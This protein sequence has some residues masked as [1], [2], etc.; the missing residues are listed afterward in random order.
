VSRTSS[1]STSS[2]QHKSFQFQSTREPIYLTI[3]INEKQTTSNN[4]KCKP[5]SL[6]L[7]LS[8]LLV[9]LTSDKTTSTCL[10]LDNVFLLQRYYSEKRALTAK[11]I[12]QLPSLR[13]LWCPWSGIVWGQHTLPSTLSSIDELPCG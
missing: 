12:E 2:W 6:Y 3:R 13:R 7:H 1:Q 9:V 10:N 5:T 4:Q 11:G 8:H